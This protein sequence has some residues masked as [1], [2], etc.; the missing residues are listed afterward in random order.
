[1]AS[2][3]WAARAAAL[4]SL[5]LLA[6]AALAD[7]ALLDDFDDLA[8]ADGLGVAAR[9]LFVADDF[10]F[11]ADVGFTDFFVFLVELT[12]ARFAGRERRAELVRA[13][14]FAMTLFFVCFFVFDLAERRA[15]ALPA[16]RRLRAAVALALDFALLVL[17]GFFLATVAL[18]R[19]SE[20]R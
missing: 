20:W 3:F 1:M 5:A 18:R 6:G 16:E 8:E 17:P 19:G 11:A 7:L 12:R 10:D 2:G 14:L 15:L 4:V 13:D 9:A